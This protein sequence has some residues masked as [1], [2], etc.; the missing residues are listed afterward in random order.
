ME[1][2]KCNCVA[3]LTAILQ[4]FRD[5]ALAGTRLIINCSDDRGR[6]GRA[7]LAESKCNEGRSPC[8]A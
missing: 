8:S 4:F 1:V 6:A 7:A 2:G 5:L 3:A